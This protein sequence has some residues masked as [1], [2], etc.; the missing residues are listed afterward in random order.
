MASKTNVK[1]HRKPKSLKTL[2]AIHLFAQKTTV[3]LAAPRK[4]PGRSLSWT[5]VERKGKQVKLSSNKTVGRTV[6]RA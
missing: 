4:F 1:R 3:L 6:S 2:F 5:V